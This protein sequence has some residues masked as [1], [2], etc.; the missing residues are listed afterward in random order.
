MSEKTNQNQE[1]VC[2]KTL[3]ARRKRKKINVEREVKIINHYA[4]ISEE[5]RFGIGVRIFEILGL[6]VPNKE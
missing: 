2:Q 3:K 4:D 5:E 1:T 6:L